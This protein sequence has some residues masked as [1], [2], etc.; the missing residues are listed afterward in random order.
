MP[1]DLPPKGGYA[2]IKFARDIPN[3]KIS[4]GMVGVGMTLLSFW[5]GYQLAMMWRERREL[6]REKLWARLYLLPLVQAEWDREWMKWRDEQLAKETEIMKDVPGWKVGESVYHN[7]RWAPPR[8]DID[9]NPVRIPIIKW[10]DT[11]EPL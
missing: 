5:G 1:Q 8:Y 3:K 11:G 4:A 2:K 6:K 9:G 7:K 10:V